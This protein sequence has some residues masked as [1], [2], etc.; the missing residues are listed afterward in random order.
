MTSATARVR[1]AKHAKK[2]TSETVSARTSSGQ[3]S[4]SPA[5]EVARE[6]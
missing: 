1:A 3:A 6:K 5:V 4:P 2:K